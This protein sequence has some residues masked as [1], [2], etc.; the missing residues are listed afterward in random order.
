GDE[1]GPLS[2]QGANPASDIQNYLNGLPS[3]QALAPG[4][5]GSVSVSETAAGSHVFNVTFNEGGDQPTLN[6]D[7]SF[8]FFSLPVSE[9]TKGANP[10]MEV[11]K[12][13]LNSLPSSTFQVQFGGSLATVTLNGADQ[14]ANAA[15]LDSA[16]DSLV[17][18]GVSVTGSGAPVNGGFG[19]FNVTFNNSGDVS[20]IGATSFATT[21][22]TMGGS[23][24]G[25]AHEVQHIDLSTLQGS[26]A[27]GSTFNLSYNGEV[28]VPL[29]RFA[30]ATDVQTALDNLPQFAGANNV[31]VTGGNGLFDVQFADTVDHAGL[32]LAQAGNQ[33][34]Q[35]IDT[36]SLAGQGSPSYRLSF[37]GQQTSPIAANATASQVEAQLNGLPTVTQAGGVTVTQ[38]FDAQFNPS[39]YDVKFNNFA[40]EPSI[41]GSVA[42][43]EQQILD[44]HNLQNETGFLTF[45]DGTNTSFEVQTDDFPFFAASDIEFAIN[46]I[47]SIPV[48]VAMLH[49]G[50]FQ[51]NYLGAGS[52]VPIE[53]HV[54]KDG[55]SVR[56]PAN[57]SIT[58]V[59]SALDNVSVSDTALTG[60]NGLFAVTFTDRGDQ[61]S[62]IQTTN[63]H[64]Q[65]RTDQFAAQGK[66]YIQIGAERTVDLPPDATADQIRLALD[67]LSAVQ[68]F[69]GV[70]TVTVNPDSSFFVTFA[71]DRELPPLQFVA[72]QNLLPNNVVETVVGDA[73]HR[74]EQTISYTIQGAF[75][76][77]KFANARLVGAI[78]DFNEIDSNIFHFF[79]LT[80]NAGAHLLN[81]VPVDVNNVPLLPTVASPGNPFTE[82]DIPIDGIVMAKLI[83][84][85]TTNFIPEAALVANPDKTVGGNLFFDNINGR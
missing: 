39:G 21:E 67:N 79:D 78:A 3:V 60:A 62:S 58:E 5:S 23:N 18:G 26:G 27:A 15:I 82:G 54:S 77:A 70:R 74:D 6:V 40:D 51:I 12:L 11:Q 45:T 59:E 43:H 2:V 10:Q 41:T 68:D 53:A 84:P 61:V 38:T 47:S 71:G 80:N 63:V 24:G 52:P 36:T 13:D 57:A 37:M 33:E 56:V 1:N 22:T 30:T 72:K 65:L 20:Q 7:D 83:D 17:P 75:D 69:G 31:T 50:V 16:L 76:A 4:N 46:S 19:T 29:S 14:A 42:V 9:T 35:H 85:K 66:F 48:N 28:T 49:P 44:L 81:G 25:L 73:N 32:I 55:N 8:N 64:Q 34:I